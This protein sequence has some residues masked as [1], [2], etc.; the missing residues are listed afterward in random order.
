MINVFIDPSL[1]SPPGY[2]ARIKCIQILVHQF[3]KLTQRKCQIVNL[4]AGFDTLFWLLWEQS[5][6]PQLFV[7]VDFTGVTARKCQYIK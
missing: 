5:L 4:G 6:H 3:L 1:P 2:Y 7:E